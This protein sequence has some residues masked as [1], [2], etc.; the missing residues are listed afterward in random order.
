MPRSE[1][2][3]AT[4]S[5]ILRKFNEAMQTSDGNALPDRFEIFFDLLQDPAGAARPWHTTSAK[6][7]ARRLADRKRQ[8]GKVNRHVAKRMGSAFQ[9][10]ELTI[11]SA[12]AVNCSM[13]DAFSHHID[14][15]NSSPRIPLLGV[16]GQISAETIWIL[17]LIGL[18]AR[19]VE[20]ASEI[21]LLLANGYHG[22]ARGRLRT[23]Y[24]TD[25]KATLIAA[26]ELSDQTVLAAR[27]YVRGLWDTY[28]RQGL[29]GIAKEDA[30]LFDA[31]RL[32]WGKRC[33]TGI[34]DWAAPA[35]AGSPKS[36]QLKDIIAS[37]GRDSIVHVYNEGNDALHADPYS[38]IRAAEFNKRQSHLFN[39]RGDINL[40]QIARTAHATVHI[41][42]TSSIPISYQV[43]ANCLDPD[44]ALICAS[45]ITSSEKA[46]EEFSKIARRYKPKGNSD[47]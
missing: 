3:D 7:S 1:G 39:M 32:K 20:L 4:D 17:T 27:Y 31:A 21:L 15:I 33:L 40:F 11:A 41:L 28:Q 36:V 8:V 30:E 24:E 35:I 29:E 23:M 26:G 43:C 13:H 25:A 37:A 38:L 12:E 10:F 6:W 34:H 14:A 42:L 44:R 45:L 18:H 22:G 19:L 46:I 5:V 9:E 16:E 47:A 2:S